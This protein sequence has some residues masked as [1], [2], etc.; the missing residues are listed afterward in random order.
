MNT[1]IICE[2][3]SQARNLRAALGDSEGRILAAQGHLLRLQAPEEVNP[4]WKVW[5]LD[6]LC[7]TEG[8]YDWRPDEGDG[9]AERL[10][11]IRDAASAAERIIIATDCDREGQMIGESLIRYLGFDGEVLRAMFT[12]EDETSV[13]AAFAALKPNN[14]WRSLYD[15]AVARA[16]CDQI[17]NLTMTR[18]ATVKLRPEGWRGALG[19]G[20]VRTPTL[21][22]VCARELE[23]RNFQ[24]RDFFELEAEIA[25]DA[26]TAS[27]W[28]RPRGEARIFDAS[29]AD[30]IAITASGYVGP[31]SVKKE[32][33]T[34]APPRPFDLP[35]LQK[36]AGKWGWTAKHV[37]DVAQALYEQ[38]KVITY[39]RAETRY[40]PE[41][42]I[43]SA[44]ALVGALA[45]VEDLAGVVPAEPVIRKG[46]S[47]LWS[48]AGIAGASHH[49][50]I[51][52]V[53]SDLGGSVAALDGDERRLFDAIARAFLAA[54]SPD[55]EF[56]ET[57]LSF[58]INIEGEDVQFQSVGKVVTNAGWKAVLAGDPEGEDEMELEGAEALPVFA[59][60]DSIRCTS[61]RARARQT[62]APK[63]FTE[64]DLIDAMQNAWKFVN[65]E[66][67]R[68]RLKEAKGIG[69]PATRDSILEGLKRQGLLVVERK[70]LVPSEMGLWLYDLLVAHAPELI[71]A[72][73]TAR[74]EG[75][76]DDVLNGVTYC[77]QVIEEICALAGDLVA[78]ISD[79]QPQAAP[80]FRRPPSSALLAAA[81]D[82]AKRDGKRLPKGAAEDAQICRDFLGPRRDPSSGP[83][84]KQLAYA[85]KLAKESGTQV[86]DEVIGNSAALSKWI[87]ASR[88][89][90]GK[91]FASPKQREWIE[92]LVGEGAKPP[93]GYPDQVRAEDA[94]SFLDKAFAS[95]PRKRK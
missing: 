76:L 80:A 57:T 30:R 60:G 12:A 71:D 43:S 36:H 32:A 10:E 14:A 90:S 75:R 83:S 65:D 40:L 2:K 52:N 16:Q 84:E 19:I 47:G 77:D 29:R 94:K 15:A 93:K 88:E 73:A 92:K 24:P 61:V 67:E 28:Y 55:H 18:V 51:P 42:L 81:R 59:D 50:L 56:D 44:P 31:L 23:I 4:D 33:R 78:K 46:K 5:G 26:G 34:A 89:A 87:D 39:P 79:A 22:I 45:K 66:A 11:E 86:P 38:H 70:N 64:G 53:N 8:R 62:T 25:G 17:F 72:G 85:S 35:A 74:M 37:L 1:I 20:R 13:K 3:P 69:T 9:K 48:N 6:V 95:K 21:G 63:R 41:N 27:L 54:V 58:S 49:A 82:K 91:A 68:E 7:P